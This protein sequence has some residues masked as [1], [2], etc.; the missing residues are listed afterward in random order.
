MQRGLTSS[1]CIRCD[2]RNCLLCRAALHRMAILGE[3]EELWKPPNTAHA[4]MQLSHGKGL[5]LGQEI[6]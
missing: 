3:T 4:A 2:S 5:A 1:P 6:F